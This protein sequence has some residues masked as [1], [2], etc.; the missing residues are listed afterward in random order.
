MPTGGES[1]SAILPEYQC[2]IKGHEGVNIITRIT[3]FNRKIMPVYHLYIFHPVPLGWVFIHLT[4]PV[5][6]IRICQAH[7]GRWHEH[8]ITFELRISTFDE[9][10]I[11]QVL[12][13]AQPNPSFC[14]S[15]ELYVPSR[16]IRLQ[17]K[18]LHVDNFHT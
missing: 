16:F 7:C 8:M 9:K 3:N 11:L 4:F 5:P 12:F 15:K 14:F 2:R 10:V 6:Y 18:R 1:Y 13:P 17:D